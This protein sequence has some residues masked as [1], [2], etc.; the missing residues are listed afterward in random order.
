MGMWTDS[1]PQGTLWTLNHHEAQ[2]HI[3][4]ELQEIRCSHVTVVS[5]TRVDHFGAVG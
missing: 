1:P 2:Q 3:A 5:G 4:V